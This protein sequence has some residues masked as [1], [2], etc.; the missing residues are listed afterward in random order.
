MTVLGGQQ[1]EPDIPGASAIAM[2]KELAGAQGISS[3]FISSNSLRW[4]IISHFIMRKVRL[5][6]VRAL[7]KVMEASRFPPLHTARCPW[8]VWGSF[9]S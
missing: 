7:L 1:Q 6:E 8:E 2:C 9:V 4:L 5:W 3:H